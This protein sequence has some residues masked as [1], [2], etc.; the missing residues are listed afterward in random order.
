MKGANFTIFTALHQFLANDTLSTI[1]MIVGIASQC[2]VEFHTKSG[3]HD[4]SA[5]DIHPAIEG[6]VGDVMPVTV[7][8]LLL[9]TSRESPTGEPRRT[10]EA[11]G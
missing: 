11:D 8:S 3:M 4:L 10:V 5:Q 6:L 9:S 2:Y 7:V 1:L